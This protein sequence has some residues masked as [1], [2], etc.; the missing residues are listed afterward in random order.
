MVQPL[1]KELRTR[2][3]MVLILSLETGKPLGQVQQHKD[4]KIWSSDVHKQR[5]MVSQLH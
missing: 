1:T 4:Q 5:R 2:E 3:A